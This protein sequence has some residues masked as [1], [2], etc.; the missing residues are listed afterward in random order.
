MPLSIDELR[1]K[2]PVMIIEPIGQYIDRRR[3][4]AEEG[5]DLDMDELC[6]SGMDHMH[7]GAHCHCRY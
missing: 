6:T 4:A 7:Q 3:R 2:Y 1:R 5:Y